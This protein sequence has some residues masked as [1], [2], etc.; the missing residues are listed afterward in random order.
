MQ[1]LGMFQ[2]NSSWKHNYLVVSTLLKNISQIGSSPQ[3]G[4]KIKNA[5]NHHLDNHT[6]FLGCFFFRWFPTEAVKKKRSFKAKE[7]Q[8][9]INATGPGPSILKQVSNTT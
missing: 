6:P 7:L 8:I 3:V 4:M 9:N 1:L 5:W 2:P